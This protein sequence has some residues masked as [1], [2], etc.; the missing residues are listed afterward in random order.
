MATVAMLASRPCVVAPQATARTSR[1]A[2]LTVARA[3]LHEQ[4]KQAN[5][6]S[7]SAAAR[8]GSAAVRLCGAAAAAAV[9]LAGGSAFARE[10]VAEFPTSGLLFRDTVKI[11]EL[12][13]D[14][15]EALRQAA[16]F[17]AWQA[18]LPP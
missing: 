3:Q 1:P 11:I 6:P 17:A 18:S 2:R 13:D 9:L 7:S 15:G 12:D 14:K 4:Q 16:T 5:A 8:V 10:K